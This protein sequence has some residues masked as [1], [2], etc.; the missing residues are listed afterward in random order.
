ML[1]KYGAVDSMFTWWLRLCIFQQKRVTKL[2][3][4]QRYLLFKCMEV[5][6][7]DKCTTISRSAK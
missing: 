2:V 3:I 4:S 1:N 6:F 5:N 7:L